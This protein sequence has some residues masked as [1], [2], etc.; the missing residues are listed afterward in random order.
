MKQMMSRQKLF[1]LWYVLKNEYFDNIKLDK[2]FDYARS[3]NLYN[4][5]PEAEQIIKSRKTEIKELET[6]EN[7]RKQI[8]DTYGC[9]DEKGEIIL[10]NNTCVFKSKEDE[11]KV[12]ELLKN[13]SEEYKDVLS[14]RQKEIDIY[15]E[16][17]QE[18]IEVDIVKTSFKY[19]PEQMNS[20]FTFVLRPMMK[21]TDEEL[22]NLL[23]E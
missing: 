13:L 20:E 11:K 10:K 17:I 7:K 18:E 21:E 16:L 19:F 14:E 22:E 9:K 1:E 6:F 2:R 15:N 23:M 12:S 3:R 5:N 8:L 4:L